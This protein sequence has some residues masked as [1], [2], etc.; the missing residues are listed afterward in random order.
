MTASGIG[1]GAGALSSGRACS[2]TELPLFLIFVSRSGTV[3][4]D[5]P[6]CDSATAKEQEIRIDAINKK[7][8]LH[9]D[10]F[11][12]SLLHEDASPLRPHGLGPGRG[13]SLL[14]FRGIGAK[15]RLQETVNGAVQRLG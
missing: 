5:P 6:G 2:G 8:R 3:T 7:A 9:I 4:S 15:A 1:T 11:I 14:R 10:S 13:K 12:V